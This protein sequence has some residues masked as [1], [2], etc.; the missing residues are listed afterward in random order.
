M[1]E[2]LRIKPTLAYTDQCPDLCQVMVI[3]FCREVQMID[4]PHWRFEPRMNDSAGE[5]CRVHLLNS[6]N[7][8]GTLIAE[9][10]QNLVDRMPIVLRVFRLLIAQVRHGEYLRFSEVIIDP[11]HPKRFEVQQMS[12]MF[13]GRP[14]LARLLHQKVVCHATDRFFQTSRS[15][16]QTSAE[17]RM[18]LHR[19]SELELPFKP[20]WR[21]VHSQRMLEQGTT[22]QICMFALGRTL[23]Y[24][25]GI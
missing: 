3:V 5:K 7:Q 19:E 6:T 1:L 23:L 8:P 14:F 17:V 10:A 4:Q 24:H 13:L 21:L 25:A 20:N 15:A 18:Q 9:V 12:S 2:I 16:A 11:R 22:T